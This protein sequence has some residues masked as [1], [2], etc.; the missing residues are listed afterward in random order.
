MVKNLSLVFI[1]VLGQNHDEIRG[2]FKGKIIAQNKFI[3]TESKFSKTIKQYKLIIIIKGVSLGNI[4]FSS[5][6][7]K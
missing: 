4:V 2:Q 5:A 3:K 7:L 6:C 1:T